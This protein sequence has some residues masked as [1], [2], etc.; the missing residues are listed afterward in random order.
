[1][2][3]PKQQSSSRRPSARHDAI[4]RA[5]LTGLLSNIG[6]RSEQHEYT[7]PRGTKFS[8]FPGSALFKANP[9]WLMAAEL[10]ET[11]K[12]YARTVAAI[13]PE[14]IERAAAH[15]IKRTYSEPHWQAASAHVVAYE[16]LT[17]RGLVIVPRRTV[18]YGPIEPRTSREIF[19]HHALVEGDYKTSADSILRNRELLDQI[20]LLQAK[21]RRDDLVTDPAHRFAFYHA[22]IP[23]DVYDGPRFEQWRREI[24]KTERELLHMQLLDVMNEKGADVTESLYPDF[25]GV[26]AMRISLEYRYEP[27]HIEDGVTAIVPLAGLNQLPVEPFEW[28]VP[29]QLGEKIDFLIRSLPKALRVLFVPVPEFVERARATLPA[30]EF[31]PAVSLRRALADFLGRIAGATIPMRDFSVEDMPAHLRT[32][33]RVVDSTG[34]TVSMGRDLAAIRQ[35]L[36]VRAKAAFATLPS[37]QWNR[38]QLTRWDFGDIPPHVEIRHAGIAL[39]GYPALLDRGNSVSMR[40]FDSPE[41]AAI[42]M[43]TGIV[44]LFMVQLHKEVEYLQQSVPNIDQLC[45]YYVPLGS[46][47]KLREEIVRAA[48]DRALFEDGPYVR[49]RL[50][51]IERAE[52]GWRHLSAAASEIQA[53]VTPALTSYHELSLELAKPAAPLLRDSFEDMRAHLARLM[54]ADFLTATPFAML[55]HL[56]RFLTG[57]KV[58]LKKL[59]TAGA[60][61]DQQQ[62][63]D[64]RL[65]EKDY[66]RRIAK[67][68]AEGNIDPRMEQF[69]WMLEEYRVS[70]FAQELKTSL[71]ISAKRLET[72][73]QTLEQ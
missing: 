31:P 66:A 63:G 55:V 72:Y 48:A 36:G 18:H 19:I 57:L 9:Q 65:F 67:L 35:F 14:W 51:F 20:L 44:R 62:L 47:H 40:L 42:S 34:N 7:A 5:L 28:L 70:L 38:D 33:F 60:I 61:R 46:C 43:R 73:W 11:T 8:V 26:G 13:Q 22:R 58:R 53:I 30:G 16:K 21:A 50:Q 69:R 17:L 59:M 29:G 24:E 15:L 27:G 10:V 2:P 56:P 4:H 41:A 52:S 71:P 45:L 68:R 3:R 1:V 6:Q 39:T 32:N 23:P 37:S 25:I 54:P 49:T 64:V 12:L